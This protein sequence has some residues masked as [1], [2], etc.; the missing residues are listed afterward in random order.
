MRVVGGKD[1][2]IEQG[3]WGQMGVQAGGLGLG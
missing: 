1:K 2:C 3:Y